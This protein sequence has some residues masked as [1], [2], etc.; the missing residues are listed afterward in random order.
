MRQL[1]SIVRR[2]IR[3]PFL[4]AYWMAMNRL[5]HHQVESW[6]VGRG[7]RIGYRSIVRPGVEMYDDVVLGDYS[8][9]SGPRSYVECARIGKF[10]SIARQVVIGPGNHALSAVTSHP[11]P[12][13]P[14]YGGLIDVVQSQQQRAAPIIGNDVWIGINSVILRGSTI[15]DGAVIAANSLVTGDVPPYAI[16]GGNPARLIRSRFEGKIVE[17]M[18]RIQWWNWSEDRLRSNAHIFRDPTEFVTRFG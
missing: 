5:H 9:V 18:Q 4:A 8:Y 14:N 16:V 10:C 11:F 3:P 12:W 7:A 15:G 6:N 17:A 1:A 2:A 13:S